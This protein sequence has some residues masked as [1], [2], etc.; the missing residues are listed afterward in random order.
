MDGLY[1]AGQVVNNVTSGHDRRQRAAI[2]D[3]T[4]NPA[5]AE[6][7]ES[8][9]RY[10]ADQTAHFMPLPQQFAGEMGAD[11]TVGASYK[12]LHGMRDQNSS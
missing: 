7:V 11:K 3:V 9:G 1:Q 2:G 6:T 8:L 4:W 10:P 12:D 5:N